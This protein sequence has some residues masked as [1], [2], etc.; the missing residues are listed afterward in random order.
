MVGYIALPPVL[1]IREMFDFREDKSLFY[2]FSSF[3]SGV[4]VCNVCLYLVHQ[5]FGAGRRGMSSRTVCRDEVF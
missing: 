2:A 4:C 1:F 5:G 3:T